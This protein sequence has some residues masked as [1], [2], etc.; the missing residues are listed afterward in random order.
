MSGE[1][2]ILPRDPRRLPKIMLLRLADLLEPRRL[3]ATL[4]LRLS[5]RPFDDRRE[6]RRLADRS[7]GPRL[8]DL[9]LEDR[10]VQRDRTNFGNGE[11]H[12]AHTL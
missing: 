5:D 2:R 10:I 7:D 12:N 4:L 3:P 1:P 8:R 9:P 11:I 6:P